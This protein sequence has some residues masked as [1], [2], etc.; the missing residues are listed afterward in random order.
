[1]FVYDVID[2][3]VCNFDEIVR[4]GVEGDVIIFEYDNYRGST[5]RFE[6]HE[7]AVA[8]LSHIVGSYAQGDNVCV[9]DG[10]YKKCE[11]LL[12]SWI[13]V[14]TCFPS[15]GDYVLLSFENFSVLCIGRYETDEE[16][17]AFYPGDEDESFISNGLIV[18][19]W[20]PLPVQYKRPN[21]PGWDFNEY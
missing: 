18:N 19:A 20:M 8:A 9:I 16:G 1:M 11:T 15:D 2:D 21:P 17:G 3:V 14:N 5:L 6:S 13:D 7:A 12:S 4:I 10:Y